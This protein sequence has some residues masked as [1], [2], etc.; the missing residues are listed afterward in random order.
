METASNLDEA[1]IDELK[2]LMKANADSASV[3]RDAAKETDASSLK[4]LF[5]QIAGTRED[6]ASTLQSA[7]AY[8]GTYE[9]IETSMAQPLRSWWMKVRDTLQSEEEVGLLSELESAEDRIK[10]A[11]EDALKKTAGSPLNAKLHGQYASIKDHH[12]RVR[13]LRDA[14]KARS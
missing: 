5:E 14:A 13:D 7:L 4:T 10:H 11:Y 3:F 6:N 9:D 12:D 8:S 1:T 2:Q